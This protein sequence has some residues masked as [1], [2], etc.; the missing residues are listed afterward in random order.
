M[1]DFLS[2]D[3]IKPDVD[4]KPLETFT[5]KTVTCT[6]LLVFPVGFTVETAKSDVSQELVWQQQ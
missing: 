6:S 4:L 1:C 2:G 5:I 3:K